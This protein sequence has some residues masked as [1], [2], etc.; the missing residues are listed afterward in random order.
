MINVLRNKENMILDPLSGFSSVPCLL[1]YVLWP[2]SLSPRSY[3]WA[4]ISKTTSFERH[5]HYAK[6]APVDF[7][8]RVACQCRAQSPDATVYGLQARASTGSDAKKGHVGSSDGGRT[9]F[10]GASGRR[11]SRGV[12]GYPHGADKRGTGKEAAL[13]HGRQLEQHRYGE[14]KVR[15]PPLEGGGI[16]ASMLP[17]F[18]FL[19]LPC[20]LSNPSAL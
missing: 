16:A 5:I 10:D 15:G 17:V 18:S 1:V 20:Q 4:E 19:R 12:Q 6:G 7:E 13:A 8:S 11:A 2:D 14:G 3:H 9:G